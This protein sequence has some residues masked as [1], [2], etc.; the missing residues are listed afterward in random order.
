MRPVFSREL[1]EIIRDVMSDLGGVGG[2][3]RA[4]LKSDSAVIGGVQ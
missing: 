3:L 1:A 4:S 2:G